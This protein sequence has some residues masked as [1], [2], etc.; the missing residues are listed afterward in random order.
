MP[1]RI[2]AFLSCLLLAG[3]AAA[4]EFPSNE[5][6]RIGGS[7]HVLK[8][9]IGALNALGGSVLVDAPVDGDLRAAAGSVKVGTGAPIA[10]DASLAGGSIVVR[11]AIQGDLHVAGGQV[12]I[13]APVTGD[14][15]VA[16]GSLTLGPQA[17]IG[18]R[19]K[20]R[21]G[22]LHRDPAA[23]VMGG[24]S[25]APSRWQRH[26]PAERSPFAHGWL[27]TAGL[28]V[29]AALLAAVFPGA[30][31]RMAQEL[32]AR[33]WHTPAVGFLAITAI[34]LA[35]V[36][37]MITLIGIPFGLLAI[38]LYVALLFVGYVWIAVVVGGMLLDRFKPETAALIAWRVGAAM[39]AMVVLAIAV[40]V[41]FVGGV[42]KFAA[43][44]AGVGMITAAV[45]RQVRPPAV[46]AG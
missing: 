2:A 4:E 36:L 11:G 43:L 34:P 6:L 25:H 9:T 13:D 17:R 38:L 8:A 10:G 33:P 18:G 7:V 12:T 37:M 23:V 45:M 21:G 27:W 5:S 1:R 14:A 39:L 40:R 35:A 31:Q 20:F 32:R 30:S 42:V 16:S 19:L 41:P 3:A 22:E 15:Y 44:L 26:E 46:A 24:V 29:L 28:V